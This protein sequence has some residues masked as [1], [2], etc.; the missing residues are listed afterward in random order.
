[1]QSLTSQN[2]LIPYLTFLENNDLFETGFLSLTL[3]FFLPTENDETDI[4]KV[5]GW[6]GHNIRSNYNRWQITERPSFQLFK[7][8]ALKY[9]LSSFFYTTSK[10]LIRDYGIEVG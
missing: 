2:E 8:A 7:K 9:E 1:M 5:S 6:E 10:E 4:S 3:G